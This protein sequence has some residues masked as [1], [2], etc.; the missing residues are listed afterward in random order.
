LRGWKL[1]VRAYIGFPGSGLRPA[2]RG[3]KLDFSPCRSRHLAE[4]PTRL[5]GMETPSNHSNHFSQKRSPTRLEG[6]ETRYRRQ[7][8]C[9]GIESPTRLEGMETREKTALD[10]ANLQ[11]PTRLEGMETCHPTCH[12]PREQT[13]L[14]PALRG[15]KRG[16]CGCLVTGGLIVSDPP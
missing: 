12:S 7:G 14:R 3:W 8:D 10:K 6:M 13:R 2:L 5:E 1:S 4:S 16:G 9:G 15:W 11:S